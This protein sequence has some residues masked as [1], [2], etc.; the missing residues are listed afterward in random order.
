MTEKHVSLSI[1]FDSWVAAGQSMNLDQLLAAKE[2]ID[3]LI[4]QQESIIDLVGSV[5]GEDLLI[6]ASGIDYSCLQKL[7]AER[8]WEDADKETAKLM[9]NVSNQDELM[10]LDAAE[11]FPIIDLTTIDRLWIKYSNGRFGLSIQKQL[12]DEVGRD[13]EKF[14]EVVGWRF[15][16]KWIQENNLTFTDDAP[17]GHLPFVRSGLSH[18]SES[19]SAEYF[20][21]SEG[22]DQCINT[23]ES[24]DSIEMWK[25]FINLL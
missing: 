24:V 17:I 14:S 5:G 13:I 1:S 3:E 9:L 8:E 11:N 19:W 7:L 22:M 6:S 2:Y 21:D 18:E 25:V 16:G 10:F 12:W 4:K 20:T 15:R 23:I